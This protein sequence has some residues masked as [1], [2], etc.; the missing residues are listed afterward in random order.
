MGKGSSLR[1]RVVAAQS[2]ATSKGHSPVGC[3]IPRQLLQEK[4][5]KRCYK[6]RFGW[7]LGNFKCKTETEERSIVIMK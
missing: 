1:G 7:C 5:L 2:G 6:E 3:A 4:T